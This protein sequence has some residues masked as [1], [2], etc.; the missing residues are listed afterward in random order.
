MAS[1][2]RLSGEIFLYLL[3]F[4]LPNREISFNQ[5]WSRY[6]QLSKYFRYLQKM[7]KH[8]QF[9]I[10]K[11]PFLVIIKRKTYNPVVFLQKIFMNCFS[12]INSFVKPVWVCCPN[13]PPCN[14][15]DT[16]TDKRHAIV[17]N[18]DYLHTLCITPRTGL[19]HAARQN[20]WSSSTRFMFEDSRQS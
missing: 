16:Q 12:A 18:T 15:T 9:P 20:C 11:K 5:D 14:G 1:W 2:E 3:W 13:P 6:L 7:S 19:T 10:Q 8:S 17:I 4:V